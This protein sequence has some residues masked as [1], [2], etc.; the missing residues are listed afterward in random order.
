M[1]LCVRYQ[2]RDADNYKRHGYVVLENPSGCRVEMLQAAL[3]QAFPKLQSF[4]DI[5]A[6]D[7]EVLD[8]PNLY[9]KGH[10]LG[11]ADVNFHEVSSIEPTDEPANVSGD[12][13]D[14]LERLRNFSS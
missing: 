9:F 7:P 5:V 4:P 13:E 3:V 8:W 11:G 14:V 10:D 6:F 2:Y 12:A 1:N